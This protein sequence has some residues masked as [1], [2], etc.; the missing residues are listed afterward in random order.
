MFQ[1]FHQ[2]VVYDGRK[3]KNHSEP[4]KTEDPLLSG[5]LRIDVTY[6]QNQNSGS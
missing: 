5:T 4:S 1:L 2:V 3:I 6:S